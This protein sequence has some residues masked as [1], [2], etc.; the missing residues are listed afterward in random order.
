MTYLVFWNCKA[1][2]TDSYVVKVVSREG[3]GIQTCDDPGKAESRGGRQ[4]RTSCRAPNLY[5]RPARGNCQSRVSAVEFRQYQ[6][7]QTWYSWLPSQREYWTG[8]GAY[9]PA[10]SHVHGPP[11]RSTANVEDQPGDGGKVVD[12]GGAPDALK[13]HIVPDV[14]KR[15]VVSTLDP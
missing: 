4:G 8:R 5:A 9:R 3:K 15:V 12:G 2:A 7:R 1:R 10:L 6:S 11:T 13:E 14:P